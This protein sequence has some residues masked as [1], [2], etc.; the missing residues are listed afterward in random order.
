LWVGWR[1]I[2]K[3]LQI[4]LFR[5][6]ESPFNFPWEAKSLLIWE[7]KIPMLKAPDFRGSPSGGG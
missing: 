7:R 2:G 5:S 4:R 6:I 3:I 1:D